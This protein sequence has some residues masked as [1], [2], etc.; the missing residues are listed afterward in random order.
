M[1]LDIFSIHVIFLKAKQEFLKIKLSII[2]KQS[3]F[4]INI[5][6]GHKC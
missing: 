4:Y 1:E 2:D 6:K 3:L 5:I